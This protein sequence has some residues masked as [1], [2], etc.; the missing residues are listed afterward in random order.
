MILIYI[1]HRLESGLIFGAIIHSRMQ[2]NFQ[3]LLFPLIKPF[4]FHILIISEINELQL[5][6]HQVF[7]FLIIEISLSKIIIKCHF[8]LLHL[9][10]ILKCH[11]SQF[12]FLYYNEMSLF[13]IVRIQCSFLT[14]TFVCIK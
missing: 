3:V 1:P 12:F 5:F 4:I 7:L 9:C 13:R 6:F 2:C 11:F 10:I 8:S 14:V